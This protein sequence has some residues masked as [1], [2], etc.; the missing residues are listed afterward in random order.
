MPQRIERAA[1]RLPG[2]DGQIVTLRV[3]PDLRRVAGE[4]VVSS[5]AFIA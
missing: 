1:T 5:N 3:Q 2:R 4:R